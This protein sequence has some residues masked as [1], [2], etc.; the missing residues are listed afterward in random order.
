MAKK[1]TEES[2]QRIGQLFKDWH[3]AQQS[4][5]YHSTKNDGYSQVRVREAQEAAKLASTA[6]SEE[7]GIATP[8]QEAV[9]PAAEQ[10]TIQ[11]S[12]LKVRDTFTAGGVVFRKTGD[13]K[14]P[15]ARTNA[16]VTDAGTSQHFV[17][18]D[19]VQFQ[20]DDSVKAV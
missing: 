17:N 3:Q 9:A 13:F 18:G 16:I 4:L 20:N 8:G 12:Q 10:T 6:L 19:V 15:G 1:I 11:F 14:H 2:A 7:F 5:A